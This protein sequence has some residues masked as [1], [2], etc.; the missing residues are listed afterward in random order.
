MLLHHFGFLESLPRCRLQR[1]VLAILIGD[2]VNGGKSAVAKLLITTVN[3]DGSTRML[4]R[5]RERHGNRNTRH[6]MEMINVQCSWPFIILGDKAK[7]GGGGEVRPALEKTGSHVASNRSHLL[8]FAHKLAGVVLATTCE[9][10]NE[11]A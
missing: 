11:F 2:T 10:R 7:I 8:V 4:P 6:E 1:E 5:D 9:L 3:V